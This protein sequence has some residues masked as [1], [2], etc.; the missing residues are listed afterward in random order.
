VQGRF[1]AGAVERAA[2]HLAVDGDHALTA[3]GKLLHEPLKRSAELLRIKAAEQTAEGVMARRAVLQLQKTPQKG[4]FRPCEQRHIDR[5]LAT[6]QHRA[7]RDQQK[8]M[9]IVNLGIAAAGIVQT[10]PALR[11]LLQYFVAGHERSLPQ[12][13]PGTNL[14]RKCQKGCTLISYAIALAYRQR[15]GFRLLVLFLALATPNAFNLSF[16]NPTSSSAAGS[17][18]VPPRPRSSTAPWSRC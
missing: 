11:K 8:F 6:A 1:S 17:Y 16:L 15:L 7:Q 2:Q 5:A 10:L 3:L 4:L 18:P 9:E 13:S 14:R 12:P